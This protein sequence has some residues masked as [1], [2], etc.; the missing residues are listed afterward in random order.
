MCPA[1]V[2]EWVGGGTLQDAIGECVREMFVFE[3]VA[4]ER[5]RIVWTVW[6]HVL[7]SQASVSD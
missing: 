5:V 3:Y 7:R 6:L 1:I 4:Y 2:L